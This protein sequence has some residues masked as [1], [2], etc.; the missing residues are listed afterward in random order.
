VEITKKNNACAT[1][2][3]ERVISDGQKKVIQVKKERRINFVES[4]YHKPVMRSLL[5]YL[6]VKTK[7]AYFK[8]KEDRIRKH[9][10]N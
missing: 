6:L 9:P 10:H 1:Q 4:I 2:V 3:A 7:A 8:C 5:I